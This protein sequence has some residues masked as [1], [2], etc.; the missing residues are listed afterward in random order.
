MASGRGV[1]GERRKYLAK[2]RL[3]QAFW[4]RRR[5]VRVGTEPLSRFT[6]NGAFTASPEALKHALGASDAKGQLRALS[7]HIEE[8][9]PSLTPNLRHE[10]SHVFVVL[11]QLVDYG[12]MCVGDV[13]TFGTQAA[14]PCS[15]ETT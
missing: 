15:V 4:K 3:G 11:Q 12:M 2:I 1:N 7:T 8:D 13:F 6:I 9:S 10:E 14:M 5:G